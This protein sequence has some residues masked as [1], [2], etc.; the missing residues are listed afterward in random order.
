MCFR[1]KTQ[2]SPDC[3]AGS[4][5]RPQ[6]QNLPQKHQRGGYRVQAKRACGKGSSVYTPE[7]LKIL[8]EQLNWIYY[9]SGEFPAVRV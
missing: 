9:E 1:S 8:Q 2:K 4:A 3:A 7:A 6:L 5:A